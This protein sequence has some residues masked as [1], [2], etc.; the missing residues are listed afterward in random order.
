MSDSGA[1]E[2]NNQAEAHD[3]DEKQRNQLIAEKLNE[4]LKLGDI[5]KLLE[6]EYGIKMTYLDLRMLAAEL[7]VD[8]SKQDSPKQ[9]EKPATVDQKD[10]GEILDEGAVPVSEVT[11]SVSKI[12]RPDAA[13]SG[14]YEC[15]SGAKGEWIVDHYGRPGMIPAEGSPKPTQEELKQFQEALVQQL[16][17]GAV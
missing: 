12:A 13:I 6:T 3:M 7:E 5:Q 15:P 17:G 4:G 1:P 8:W 9:T 16:Q 2:Y 14:N 11:V 10:A